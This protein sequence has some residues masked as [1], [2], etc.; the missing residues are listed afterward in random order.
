MDNDGGGGGS[1]N[2]FPK[3]YTSPSQISADSGVVFE[4]CMGATIIIGSNIARDRGKIDC[5]TVFF[6]E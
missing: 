3:W 5:R 6:Y 4:R 2:G 1:T